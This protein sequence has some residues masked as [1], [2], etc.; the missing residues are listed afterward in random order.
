[1]GLPEEQAGRSS[2]PLSI[3]AFADLAETSPRRVR[4]LIRQGRLRTVTNSAGETRI[5][6]SEL[7][8]MEGEK[9]NRMLKHSM[10]LAPVHTSMELGYDDDDDQDYQR[11][12]ALV[13]IQRHEAAMVRLGFMESEL[14]ATR[15]L[16]AE[17]AQRACEL[18]ER[19]CDA[20]QDAVSATVRAVEAEHALEEMRTQV[21]DS[22]FKAMELQRELEEI[23]AELRTPWWRKLL[24]GG[25]ARGKERKAKDMS[26]EE[27]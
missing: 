9:Q 18:E 21:I 15:R 5:P 6:E 7:A 19:A 24:S 1:M 27:D 11:G 22:T 26:G 25:A 20:E 23:H 16:L 2:R 10:E 14:A 17:Q 12:S 8:R 4:R 3:R 13:S